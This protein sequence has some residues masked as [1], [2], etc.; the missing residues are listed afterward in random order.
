MFEIARVRA[1][2]L[3]AEA[4]RHRLARAGLQ[5]QSMSARDRFFRAMLALG[6]FFIEIGQGMARSR[7]AL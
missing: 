6:L 3:R 2:E 7:T 4:A 5:A 1:E